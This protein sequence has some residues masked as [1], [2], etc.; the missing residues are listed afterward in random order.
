MFLK[1]YPLRISVQ[2]NIDR[3]N[4]L[5]IKINSLRLFAQDICVIA[6]SQRFR[7]SVIH[8]YT[9]RVYGRIYM[10]GY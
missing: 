2:D 7:Y 6:F 4:I 5:L 3:R 8:I 1:K 9:S 10:V